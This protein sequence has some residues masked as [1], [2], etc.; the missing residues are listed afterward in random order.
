MKIK[1]IT[2]NI[3]DKSQYIKDVE[4]IEKSATYN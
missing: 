2:E 3:V 1:R 4:I